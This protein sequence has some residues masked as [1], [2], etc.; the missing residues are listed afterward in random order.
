[1][2]KKKSCLH[3]FVLNAHSWISVIFGQKPSKKLRLM[4]GAIQKLSLHSQTKRTFADV[5]VSSNLIF[6]M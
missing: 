1:M 5:G 6:S 2:E 3:M 4:A